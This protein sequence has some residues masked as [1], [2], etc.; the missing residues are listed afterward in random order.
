MVQAVATVQAARAVDSVRV[1]Q[2]RRVASGAAA[3]SVIVEAHT[4]AMALALVVL[5][6][7]MVC[8]VL[9]V[10]VAAA[11]VSTATQVV[12]VVVVAVDSVQDRHVA[13]SKQRAFSV[14]PPPLPL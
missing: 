13:A 3:T 14:L 9:A 1:A 5:A 10:V 12:A 8:V 11:A 6:H 2:V 4:E 7:A